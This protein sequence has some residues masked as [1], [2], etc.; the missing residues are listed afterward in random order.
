MVPQDIREEAERYAK[1]ALKDSDSEDDDWTQTLLSLSL[2]YIHYVWDS[3]ISTL[4][5][6]NKYITIP[7]CKDY[8]LL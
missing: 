6:N 3:R 4:F 5:L 7:F 8:Q 1:E 2:L